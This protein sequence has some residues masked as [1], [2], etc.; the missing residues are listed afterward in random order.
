[1]PFFAKQRQFIVTTGVFTKLLCCFSSRIV[2]LKHENTTC[3]YLCV[4]GCA[5][6]CFMG[7]DVCNSSV[8]PM[9]LYNVKVVYEELS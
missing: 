2:N 9:S 1:M 6:L 8:R 3:V 7:T 5:C 4:C